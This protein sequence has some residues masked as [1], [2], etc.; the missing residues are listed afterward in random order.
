MGSTCY[1]C[2][3]SVEEPEAVR[4][5]GLHETCFLNWF[6]LKK[7]EA[8]AGLERKSDGSPKTVAGRDQRWTSSFFHGK[9]LKYSASLGAGS[10][11][12]KMREDK[13]PELPAVEY[14]CNQLGLLLQLPIPPFFLIDHF[15]VL[16]FVT[17]NFIRSGS[18][19]P[20]TL[21]HIY[22]Y[23][24][25]GDELECETL[26]NIIGDET[27]Q[28]SDV[29]TFIQVCLFDSLIGNND[30]HGRNLGFIV[31]SKGTSLSPIYDN[32]SALGVESG[33]ILRADFNPKGLIFTQD[34]K[35]PTGKDYV[36]E[37]CRLGYE[38]SVRE[39]TAKLSMPDISSL[40]AAS[41]CSDLM[42][43]SFTR[44]LNKRY[45]ELVDATS[46]GS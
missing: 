37:F 15:G 22:H 31:T 34:S 8:F 19:T 43:E 42:K 21:N 2:M 28:Y 4:A 26:I 29:E 5:Y 7:V 41:N 3:N 33:T 44:L 9:F 27:K 35:E 14:L 25:D 10:Y 23:L 24:K 16:T 32:T 40:V 45:K 17:K 6:S 38:D 12:L 18:A 20:I 30:R 36:T 46:P 1:K 11:I 39:F 13:Y